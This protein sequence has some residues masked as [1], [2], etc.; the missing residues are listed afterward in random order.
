MLA[1]FKDAQTGDRLS[2]S[3]ATA[4]QRLWRLPIPIKILGG[5]AFE[6]LVESRLQCIKQGLNAWLECTLGIKHG[7]WSSADYNGE[8][9]F[10][11]RRMQWYGVELCLMSYIQVSARIEAVGPSSCNLVSHQT[12]DRISTPKQTS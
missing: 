9:S 5:R 8:V 11:Q 7:G 12:D 1:A 3:R 2:W 10:S 4:N 6:E